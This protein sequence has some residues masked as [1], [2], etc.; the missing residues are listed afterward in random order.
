MTARIAWFDRTFNFDF[1]A[2]T[3]PELMERLRG[4]PA[5]LDERVRPLPRTILT[6]RDGV[7]WS[8]QEQAGH[9]MDLEVLWMGRVDDFVRGAEMLRAADLTNQRTHD[10][11]HN[12]Q[13]IEAL[14]AGFRVERLALIKRLES[15]APADF[16]NTALHPRLNQPMRVCDC[17][18][19][20]AEHDD[21]HLARITELVQR[22]G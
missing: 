18:S 15:F 19:F 11:N 22:I 6:V 3:Y 21:Y 20:I 1:P 4:T 17:M 12:Q 14:L 8:I 16:A 5:R 9:L 7:K 10:A 2:D 13:D